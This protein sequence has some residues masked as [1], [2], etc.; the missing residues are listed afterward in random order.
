LNKS[1]KCFRSATEKDPQYALAF[2]G[3]AEAHILLASGGY[4]KEPQSETLSKA[5]EA[6]RRSIELDEHCAEAHVSM[7]LV[8]FR[9]EW[10]F[11]HAEREFLRGLEINE[12]YASGHHHYAMLLAMTLRIDEAVGQIERARELDPLS[13]IISTAVG[14]V[15][16]FARRYGDAIA[17]CKRTVGLDPKFPNA[18]FDLSISYAQAGKFAEAE[19]TMHKLA[20][21]IDNRGR[22]LILLCRLEAEKG[23]REKALEHHAQLQEFSKTHHI[24]GYVWAILDVGLREYDR[25]MAWLQRAYEER[26]PP[27]LYVQ[28]EHFWDPL[29]SRPDYQE[30]IRKIGFP[31]AK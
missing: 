27:L 18:Y 3:L 22:E 29:R 4:L 1:L 13:L 24:G 12:G 16:Y 15:Y 9:A 30:L 23:N 26:D 28:C 8:L 21:L 7:G 17:Q 20:E 14:R 6:A 2:A 5:R 11:A 31:A 10:D 19:E 25:A